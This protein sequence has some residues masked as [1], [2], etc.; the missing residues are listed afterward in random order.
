MMASLAQTYSPHPGGM[1]PHPGMAQGHPMVPHN[2]QQQPGP[3]MPQQMHMGVSGPGPQVSQGAM[4][5]GM[6]PGA[7]GPSAHALQHLNPAQSQQAQQ[8]FQQQQQAAMCKSPPPR[9]VV[10]FIICLLP[11]SKKTAK[12]WC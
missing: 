11:L 5:A 3:G 9:G 4:M 8:M 1:Q 2:P 7:V 6:P 12:G 10:E